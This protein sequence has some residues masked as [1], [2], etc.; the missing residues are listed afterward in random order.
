MSMPVMQ[1]WQMGMLVRQRLMLVT[2]AVWFGSLV[3]RVRM[4]MML[5]MRVQVL[6]LH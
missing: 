3:T 2:V 6:V 4:L 1:V 5:V